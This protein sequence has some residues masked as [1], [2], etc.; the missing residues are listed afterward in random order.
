MRFIPLILIATAVLEIMVF[1]WAGQFIGF[2]ST[3]G[4]V[5]TSAFV[6]S[7]LVRAQ[8]MKALADFQRSA[9]TGEGEV[10][11]TIFT[12]LCLLLAGAFLI[13]PGFITDTFGLLLLI[14]PLRTR[15][16]AALK[17]RLASFA[18]SST[19]SF[20]YDRSYSRPQNDR[21]GGQ[22]NCKTRIIDVEGEERP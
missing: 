4:L 22:T 15:V 6:G 12:G 20:S 5:L 16:Y 13:T 10:G 3:V 19:T 11:L 9:A 18:A 21:Q 14:P 17:P 1:M 2:W 8:G 7:F